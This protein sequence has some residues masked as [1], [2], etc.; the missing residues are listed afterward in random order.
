[1]TVST[2]C[3]S[4]ALRAM[5]IRDTQKGAKS[6]GSS[7]G[8]MAEPKPVCRMSAVEKTVPALVPAQTQLRLWLGLPL[9]LWASGSD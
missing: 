2:S 9:A 1:M 5:R 3:T 6:W 8:A 7:C 4:S